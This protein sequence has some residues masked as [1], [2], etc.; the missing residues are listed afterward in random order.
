MSNLGLALAFKDMG[1]KL[2]RTK[3]GDRY[4]VKEMRKGGY[5]VGGEQSGH[6]IFLDHSTT[7]DGVVSALKVL[8]VMLREQQPLSKLRRVMTTVPQVLLNKKVAKKTPLGKL[9]KVQRA[10]KKIEKALGRE[11]RVLVRY[12]G[13]ENK[14][15]VMIEG[16]D[17]RKIK[18]YAKEI[19]G[20]F[21][22]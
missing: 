16:T 18:G 22:E 12:S 10:I 20:H 4:V 19:L 2:K 9:P 7:G 6:L 21:S 13:T 8:T 17:K 14:V 1:I 15:R 3:V 5:N 11:G